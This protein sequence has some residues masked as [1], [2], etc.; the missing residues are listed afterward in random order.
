MERLKTEPPRPPLAEGALAVAAVA[1]LVVSAVNA[2]S[3]TAVAVYATGV[4]LSIGLG[5]WRLARRRD[6]RFARLLIAAGAFWAL[7]SFAQSSDS[8]LYSIGRATA[9]FAEPV[10]VYLILAYPSGILRTRAERWVAGGTAVLAGLLYLPTALLAEYPEPSPW[11]ACG[12]DCPSNALVLGDGAPGVV[13]VVRPLRELIVIALWAAVAVLL[14]RR[15]RTASPLL[16]RALEP[17]AAIAVVRSFVMVFYLV[18]RAVWDSSAFADALGWAYLAS[19]PA[20]ALAFVAGLLNQRLFAANALEGLIHALKPHAGAAELRAAMASALEDPS[21]RVVY[22]MEGAPGRWVD[23]SG[24]PS[25]PPSEFEGRVATEVRSDG[26][27]VAAILHDPELARDPDLVEAASAYALTAL[28]NERLALRLRAANDDLRDSRTRVVAAAD[29]ERRRIERDLHDGAQQRLV[30]LRM[31]LGLLAEQLAD[32]SEVASSRVNDLEHD[33]EATIDEV[34]SFARDIYP[35]LLADRGLTEALRAVARRSP[36]QTTLDAT[37]VGRYPLAIE[38]TVYFACVEALQNAAKHARGAHQA[39]ISIWD[40]GR[41]RFRVDDDGEGFD[42]TTAAYGNGL[43]NLSDRL[44]ALGGT[45]DVESRPGG[46]TRVS[47]V[48]PLR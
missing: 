5:L 31:K 47:G 39:D 23:E 28:E 42:A 26:R 14:V 13:D 45:L 1:L 20:I 48:I 29:A 10:F 46:G 16:R 43:T 36:I 35:L 6:E 30:A 37:G 40:D 25:A 4:A 41:L 7:T 9:W 44:A 18:A 22:W 8:V 32:G 3:A 12:T 33:V 2:G 34:R 17:V 11:G 38:S 24:W 15:A 19:L 27:L 21:L